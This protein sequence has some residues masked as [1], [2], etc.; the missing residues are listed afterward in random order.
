MPRNYGRLIA[1]SAALH[2]GRRIYNNARWAYRVGS[3]LYYGRNRGRVMRR[4]MR[5]A[6]RYRKIRSGKR[7]RFGRSTFAFKPGS[8]LSRR[9]LVV[10]NYEFS[11]NTRTLF[12]QEL[13]LLQKGSAIDE[14]EYDMVYISGFKISMQLR[15]GRPD[16]SMLHVAVVAPREFCGD[17]ATPNFN[18]NFFRSPKDS[19]GI[20]FN[21][22]LASQQINNYGIN[23]DKWHV[24]WHKRYWI[25][26][27]D[28]TAPTDEYNVGV[29]R[30]WLNVKK[31]VPLK[32]QIRYED[33]QALSAVNKVYLLVWGDLFINE[34]GATNQGWLAGQ[35]VVTMYF[36]DSREK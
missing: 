20:D 23:S 21:T 1:A 27:E 36:R 34:P 24:F 5:N 18:T 29:S 22:Q 30:N 13:T 17:G 3:K 12:P 7:Q 35:K 33:A 16:P 15:S 11:L 2:H 19:R 8:S 32:R 4:G 10:E 28:T 25:G 31:Y 9:N 26:P 14:R 6:R